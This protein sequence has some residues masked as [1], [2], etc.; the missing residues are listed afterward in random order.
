MTSAADDPA[1]YVGSAEDASTVSQLSAMTAGQVNITQTLGTATSALG[2]VATAL[3]RIQ[4]I[5]LQAINGATSS[6]DL[7]ALGDEVGSGLTQILS[8]ANSQSSDGN[9]VFAGTAKETE[10]FV[11]TGSGGVNYVAMTAPRMW[12]SRPA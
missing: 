7:P 10:P 3:D 4:S 8:L 1:A 2:D 11:T 6:A 5:A 12:K 9:Y